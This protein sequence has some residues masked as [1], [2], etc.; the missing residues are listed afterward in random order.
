MLGRISYLSHRSTIPR[1][2]KEHDVL[3][4]VISSDHAA[5]LDAGGNLSTKGDSYHS[6]SRIWFPL[7]S[8]QSDIYVS[9]IV[10]FIDFHSDI[11]VAK[12]PVLYT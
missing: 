10:D 8:L 11:R 9:T 6:I 4:L 12:S 1:K 7:G 2:K 5:R 3:G